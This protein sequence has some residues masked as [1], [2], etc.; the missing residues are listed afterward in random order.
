MALAKF[1]FDLLLTPRGAARDPSWEIERGPSR[2]RGGER[3][4]LITRL[5]ALLATSATLLWFSYA[6]AR[7]GLVSTR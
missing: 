1:A 7:W 3:V 4:K 6:L 2:M 5:L